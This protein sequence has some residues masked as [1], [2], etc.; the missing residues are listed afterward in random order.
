MHEMMICQIEEYDE[1]NRRTSNSI[2]IN[3]IDMFD[4]LLQLLR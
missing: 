2:L 4:V 3:S 1:G